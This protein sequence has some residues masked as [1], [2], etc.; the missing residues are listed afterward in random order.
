MGNLV[1]VN[2]ILEIKTK[3]LKWDMHV[4]FF[5][6]LRTVYKILMGN[7]GRKSSFRRQRRK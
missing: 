1:I 4:I 3:K 6:E 7:P 5:E 2:I